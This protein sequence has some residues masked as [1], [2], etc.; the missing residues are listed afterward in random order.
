LFL[1]S[2]LIILKRLLYSDLNKS[3]ADHFWSLESV[4]KT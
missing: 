3:Q 2:V 4:F 1:I